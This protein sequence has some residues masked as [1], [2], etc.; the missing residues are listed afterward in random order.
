MLNCNG[1]EDLGRK[2]MLGTEDGDPMEKREIFAVSLRRERKKVIL[3][4]RRR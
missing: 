2:R 3:S 4:D 1:I